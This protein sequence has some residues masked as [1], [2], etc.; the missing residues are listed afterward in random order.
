MF[1]KVYCIGDREISMKETVSL[2]VGR[3]WCQIW[4]PMSS[5][6]SMLDEPNTQKR[7]HLKPPVTLRRFFL[8]N[9]RDTY[10][11]CQAWVAKETSC[12]RSS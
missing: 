8:N 12:M 1:V 9:L 4:G 2:H 10:R 6:L 5:I 3:A 7:P 11:G